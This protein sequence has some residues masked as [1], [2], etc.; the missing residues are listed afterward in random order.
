M[1]IN[2][3]IAMSFRGVEIPQ[4]NALADY[5]AIQ[6]IQGG[7]RQAEVSQMQLAKMRREESGLD[8][9]MSAIRAKGGP[10]DPMVAAQAMIDSEIPHFMDTG[11][12]LQAAAR[13]RT[14]D[15][16]AMGLSPTAA[17]AAA[18]AAAPVSE[19]YP[20]YSE[21][22]GM[23]APTNALAPAASE[24]YP[25]YNEAIGMTPSVN[26]MAPAAAAPSVN[27]MAPSADREAQIRSA[28]LKMLSPTAGVRD[29][30]KME[31]EKLLAPPPFRSVAAGA[32]VLGPDN[33]VIF[34]APAAAPTPLNVS[35]LIKER[36]ALLPG[37][38]NIA[39]YNDAIRKE[40]QFAPQ[41]VTSIRNIANVNPNDFTPA[42]VQK[43]NTS[44]DYGDLR[45]VVKAG[46]GVA[47]APSGAG[48]PMTDLQ[49][50]AYRKDFASDTSKIKSATD[51]ADELENLTDQ[52]V[53]NPDK[54][55]PPHPGLSGITGYTGLL[56]SFAEG[57]LT[58]GNAAKAEQKLETF[59][60]K[61]KALGRAI[62]SQEGKLGNM[63]VAEWQMVS[64]AVQAIKPTAGNLDEQMR[65]VVRQAR[66]IAKNMQDK[67]DLTYEETPSVAGKPAAAP[68]ASSLARE[69]AEAAAAIAAG[70]PAAAVRQR[71]K[72]NTGQEL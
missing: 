13:Q 33:K 1:P 26:A 7:Q 16:A 21:S 23:P 54:K 57:A 53:G 43:F 61:I 55:I 40:T 34:T 42:S 2:P 15:M 4:Q 36:D 22:I 12:K 70:A 19:P 18:A 28:K 9:M 48:K 31:L 68:A 8:R 35:R 58:S 38:P 67:F 20:G 45:A 64:D 39:I 41:A 27:A 29:A 69:R 47:K 51:I 17:P 65:D 49:K 56:P 25:G 24:P 6:Q 60:G 46:A 11:F 32:S 5:A 44:G 37:D 52:L 3:N 30:G 59:K 10:S 14:E 71:F 66:V 50:Q 63:A 62:A 72:Q